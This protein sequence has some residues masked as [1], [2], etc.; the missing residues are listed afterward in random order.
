MFQNVQKES[1]DNDHESLNQEKEIM[2][3]QTNEVWEELYWENNTIVIGY[4]GWLV[5]LTLITIRLKPRLL[6][7]KNNVQDF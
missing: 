5:I 3:N 6:R 7:L 1:S 2:S 4:S